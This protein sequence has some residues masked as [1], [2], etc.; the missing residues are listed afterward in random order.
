M[1]KEIQLSP[2]RIV[3]TNN[4]GTYIELSDNDGIEI[5]SEGQ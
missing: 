4:D 5:V 2:E 3:Q 1:A